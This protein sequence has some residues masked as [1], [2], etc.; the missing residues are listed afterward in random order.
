MTGYLTLT[1]KE[2]KSGVFGIDENADTPVTVK[3]I[4]DHT[5]KKLSAG[6]S[7]DDESRPRG[8]AADTY[9]LRQL[10]DA[11]NSS[12]NKNEVSSSDGE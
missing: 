12:K 3:R 5:A 7:P 2:Y 11:V 6:I 1:V 8:P 9:T 4:Y 10:M